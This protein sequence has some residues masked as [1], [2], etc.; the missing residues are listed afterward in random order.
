MFRKVA[1]FLGCCAL[2]VMVAGG[3]MVGALYVGAQNAGRAVATGFKT[4]PV[5]VAMVA[6][7]IKYVE[8]Q[9]E[10]E[11]VVNRRL[12]GDRV[13]VTEVCDCGHPEEPTDGIVAINQAMKTR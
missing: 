9:E 5:A 1:K 12:K 3:L 11:Y 6:T 13:A 2:I 7:P 4:V 10:P 8:A